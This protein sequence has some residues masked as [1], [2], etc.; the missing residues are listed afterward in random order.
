[1]AGV[2]PDRPSFY[3]CLPWWPPF[4]V[5]TL[6]VWSELA[7]HHPASHTVLHLGPLVDSR[8]PV[9]H[10]YSP[11]WQGG[12]PK[13]LAVHVLSVLGCILHAGPRRRVVNETDAAPAPEGQGKW[14]TLTQECGGTSGP[15]RCEEG[16]EL[17]LMVAARKASWR[18]WPLTKSG[19]M[20]RV[21]AHQATR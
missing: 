15:M 2:Q 4:C 7:P 3:P 14:P 16:I 12:R 6:L 8:P 21:R 10:G 18:R 19:G 13:L 5:V 20:S 17:A 1:M 9:C 11:T